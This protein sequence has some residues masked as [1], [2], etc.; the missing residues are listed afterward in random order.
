MLLKF[1][2]MTYNLGE[3]VMAEISYKN[4]TS[5]KVTMQNPAKSFD[6]LMRALDS[7]SKE[8][9]NYTM[10]KI[11]VTVMDKSADQY[12][13]ST[14]Q[15]KMV[16][17][18]K[19]SSITFSS[20]LND[21]LY[22]HPGDF[23]CLLKEGTLESNPVAISVRFTRESILPLTQIA[24]DVNMSFGRREWAADWLQKIYAKLKLNLPLDEDA[25]EI[26]KEKES[27]N[28]AMIA[29]FMNWWHDNQNSDKLEILIRNANTGK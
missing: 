12:A 23:V 3:S 10:G 29:E 20:D 24:K 25:P 2:K 6:I 13:K 11:E 17:I 26:R 1:S 18:E 5:E 4:E 19:D 21:R 9:L 14:P 16:T 22:L 15:K 7:T 27:Y 8:E 28:G